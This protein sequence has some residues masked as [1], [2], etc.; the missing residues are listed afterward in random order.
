MCHASA[1][2]SDT[3]TA[4]SYSVSIRAN[5]LTAGMRQPM[6]ASRRS[7]AGYVASDVIMSIADRINPTKDM[8]G[9]IRPIQTNPS[10]NLF[11]VLLHSEH[12]RVYIWRGVLQVAYSVYHMLSS[13]CRV[14]GG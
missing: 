13:L 10:D 8:A 6:S 5:I 3:A 9:T 12:L 1:Y 14:R 7:I 2:S 11:N 4:H